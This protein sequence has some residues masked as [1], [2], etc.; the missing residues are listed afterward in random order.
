MFC[1]EMISVSLRQPG[2]A[3]SSQMAD[4][5]YIEYAA[6]NWSPPSMMTSWRDAGRRL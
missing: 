6:E 1:S 3:R 2:L 5:G 4:D